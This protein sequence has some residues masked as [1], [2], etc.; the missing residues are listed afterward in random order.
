MIGELQSTGISV[1]KYIY[2]ILKND[3]KLKEMVGDNIYPLIAEQS[4]TFPFIIF[5]KTGITTQYTK[6][7]KVYDQVD[8]S[9]LIISN[10]YED[11]INVAERVRELIE[12]TSD[13][14]LKYTRLTSVNEDYIDDSYVQELS[15]TTSIK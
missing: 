8:F 10:K 4:V 12:C 11:S 9:I 3:E 7:L 2:S 1:S 6:D 14:N 13:P 15:F 5:K